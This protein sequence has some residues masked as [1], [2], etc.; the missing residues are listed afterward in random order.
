M[1]RRCDSIA[2]VRDGGGGRQHR[3]GGHVVV[4]GG[5]WGRG[6]ATSGPVNQ[7]R[8]KRGKGAWM[9]GSGHHWRIT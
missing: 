1:A 2:Q 4:V 9:R 3:A 5:D 7:L 8:G 6:V